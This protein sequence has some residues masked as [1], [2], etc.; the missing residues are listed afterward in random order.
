MI[1]QVTIGPS[2]HHGYINFENQLAPTLELLTE[3]PE[4]HIVEIDFIYHDGNF[5]S[6]HDYSDENIALGSTIEEWVRCIINTDKTLWIDVKDSFFSIWSKKFIKFDTIA[7]YEHLS[8]LE[9]EFPKLKNHIL[10][11]C[12]Y[13]HTYKRLV[14][15]NTGHRI[16]HD[17]PPDY[18]YVLNK[19]FGLSLIKSSIHNIIL[20]ELNGVDG[21]VCLDRTFFDNTNELNIFIQ[22]LT[23]SVIIIYSYDLTDFD[24]PN[25]EGKHIIYQ[26]NYTK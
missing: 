17:T 1:D 10:I 25:V 24:L 15:H 14:K 6:S 23:N 22:S 7:F 11:G 21:I 18:A 2:A 16:I 20:D 19:V 12:Q 5:I 8:R 13:K 9:L 4:I 26:Y 3:H